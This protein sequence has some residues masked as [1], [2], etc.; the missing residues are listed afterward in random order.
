MKESQQS[1]TI[2]LQMNHGSLEFLDV[3]RSRN[4][5]DNDLQHSHDEMQRIVMLQITRKNEKKPQTW[6]A[7]ANESRQNGDWHARPLVNVTPRS[8][9]HGY[10]GARNHSSA[11]NGRHRHTALPIHRQ[12]LSQKPSTLKCIRL[13]QLDCISADFF[14]TFTTPLLRPSNFAPDFGA[15][16]VA[17]IKKITMAGSPAL[18]R[19]FGFAREFVLRRWSC[20]GSKEEPWQRSTHSNLTTIA[21]SHDLNLQS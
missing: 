3:Y 7:R 9:K 8:Q 20:R 16:L 14:R 2:C 6:S 17:W 5:F 10:H 21:L 11:H 15:Q 4:L 18:L 1:Y 13:S 19:G 12:L